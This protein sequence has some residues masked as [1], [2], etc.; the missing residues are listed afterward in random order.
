LLDYGLEP[1]NFEPIGLKSEALEFS[2]GR[3]PLKDQGAM[4]RDRAHPNMKV[5]KREDL[6]LVGGTKHAVNLTPL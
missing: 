5:G 2:C 4:I 3:V 6:L 1:W